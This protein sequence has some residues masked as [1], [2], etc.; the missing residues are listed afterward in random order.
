MS[1]RDFLLLFAVCLVWGLNIVLTRWV[2]ADVGVPP[3]FFAAVRFTGVAVFLIPF[4]RPKPPELKTLFVIALL[5]GSLNF[6]LLFVGL[7]NAEASAAAVTGQLGVPISTLM[8]MAFLGETIGWRRGLGIMLAFA[9]VVL[10]AVD[11]GSF[12][13]SVGLLYIVGSAFI[14]SAGGILMKRMAPISGLQLQ[15]WVGLFSFLPL[16]LF[17]YL[18]ET[19]Q[20]ATYIGAGWPIWLA[21]LFAIV[22]VSIFGHG[23]FYTL[24]KKY[25][26]SLL[27]PLTLM[28]PIWGVIFGIVLLN[29]PITARLVLGSVISLSGVFVIAIRHNTRMPEAAFGK[30]LGPG[31]S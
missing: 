12:G 3:L 23:A 16:F 13:V 31:D 4:L 22:G 20:V 21:S 30:K 15:A 1:F 26:V 28:T 9:G 5:I 8:S 11:P 27:S 2:V 14:G 10:I 19:G 29:E 6:A 18:F 17:S 24:I 25:D 7:K